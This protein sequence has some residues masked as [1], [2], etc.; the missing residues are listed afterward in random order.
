MKLKHLL[1]I[2]LVLCISESVFGQNTKPNIVF[3]MADDL[4]NT[5]LSCHVNPYHHTPNID[6]R[7]KN[8]L[9]FNRIN[10]KNDKRFF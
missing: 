9:K 8:G 7:A 2:S 3:I 5:D 4:G 10:R 1:F 6:S